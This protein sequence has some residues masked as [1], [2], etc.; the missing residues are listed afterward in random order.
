L[1]S[2]ASDTDEALADRMEQIAEEYEKYDY[3]RMT[4]QLHREG[5]DVN[6]KTVAD[7]LSFLGKGE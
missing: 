6:H 3:R 4:A 7:E 2:S 5:I 1:T